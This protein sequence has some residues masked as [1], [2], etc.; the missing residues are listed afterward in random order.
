MASLPNIVSEDCVATHHSCSQS[1]ARNAVKEVIG[2]V[3]CFQRMEGYALESG[4]KVEQVLVLLFSTFS[5]RPK[6]LQLLLA[7][8]ESSVDVGFN[9]SNQ[10]RRHMSI[11][12]G[13]YIWEFPFNHVRQYVAKLSLKRLNANTVFLESGPRFFALEEGFLRGVSIKAR[14]IKLRLPRVSD[15]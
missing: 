1:K 3:V 12:I 14:I 13:P 8:V 2:P 11:E 15:Y 6:R 4:R 9:L 10:L 7:F 5:A